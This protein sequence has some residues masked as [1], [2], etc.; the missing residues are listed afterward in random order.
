MPKGSKALVKCN[1]CTVGHFKDWKPTQISQW[2]T[3]C[4]G[5]HTSRLN[6][7]T[8]HLVISSDKWRSEHELVKKAKE[9]NPG[10]GKGGVQIVSW[11]WLEDSVMNRTRRPEGTYLWAKLEPNAKARKKVQKVQVNSSSDADESDT[12]IAAP[13]GAKNGA[14]MLRE[15]FEDST[16]RYVSAKENE[17]IKRQAAVEKQVREQ[18]ARDEER[19]RKTEEEAKRFEKGA[20]KARNEIFSGK[21]ALSSVDKGCRLA[22]ANVGHQRIII[23]LPMRPASNTTSL[24]PKSTPSTIVTS[25][26][27]SR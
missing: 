9:M 18:I 17:K 5:R 6:R 21:S 2:I 16:N 19:R 15:V 1:I 4:G 24:S 25:A 8:T 3:G 23:S 13:K 7:E 11:D 20:K 27:S 26:M 12:E 22:Q 10:Q 14:G